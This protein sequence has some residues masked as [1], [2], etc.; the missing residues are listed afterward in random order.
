MVVMLGFCVRAVPDKCKEKR[1]YDMINQ[2]PQ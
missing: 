1:V 2:L